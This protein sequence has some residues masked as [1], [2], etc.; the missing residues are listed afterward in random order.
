MPSPGSWACSK[1]VMHRLADYLVRRERRGLLQALDP[2][3]RLLAFSASLSAS[4]LLERPLELLLLCL[5][6]LALA[7][8]ARSLVRAARVLAYSLPF[9]ALVFALDMAFGLALDE[10]LGVAL[11]LEALIA[12]SF[13]LFFTTSPDE[14]DEVLAWMRVP[15]NLRLA[16]TL[17]VRYLP[18]LALDVGRV[19]DA[20]RSRGL[21]FMQRNPLRAARALLP[22]LIPCM[23]VALYRSQAVAEAM[24]SR[25]YGAK[26]RPGAGRLRL[27]YLDYGALALLAPSLLLLALNALWR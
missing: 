14:V 10:A 13:L 2:R 25:G 18:L 27:S 21:S 17:A 1:G 16:F 7:A 6:L 20:Q 4:V 8:L 11:R 5:L 22:L 23:A 3:V 26:R 19:M 15:E 12:S 9:S 24:I